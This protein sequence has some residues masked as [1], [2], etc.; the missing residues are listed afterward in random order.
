MRPCVFF[1]L[2]LARRWRMTRQVR[3]QVQS[4]VDPK[5]EATHSKGNCTKDGRNVDDM[6]APACVLSPALDAFMV[7]PFL[8]SC[9]FYCCLMFFVLSHGIRVQRL[10]IPLV[11]D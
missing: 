7:F 10:I 6:G 11:T 9:Q 3:V 1:N 4:Q 8:L 5:V 2:V